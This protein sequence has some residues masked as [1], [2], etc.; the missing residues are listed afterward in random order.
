M[1]AARLT[2]QERAVLC[3]FLGE[4]LPLRRWFRSKARQIAGLRIERD[5]P[6]E[7][8]PGLVAHLLL[9]GVSFTSG[10]AER[11]FMARRAG[12]ATELLEHP[13]LHRIFLQLIASGQRLGHTDS[14]LVGLPGARASAIPADV[15]SR[16]LALE[17][18]NSAIAFGDSHFLKLFRVPDA[19]ES[20]DIEL[21]RYLTE[22][23][24][25]PN[26]APFVGTLEWHFAGEAP[27]ILGV[28][29]EMVPNRGD[30]WPE[31]IRL[32]N[33]FISTRADE[34]LRA[35]LALAELLG[36]RTAGMHTAFASPAAP[37]AIAPE[38]MVPADLHALARRRADLAGRVETLLATRVAPSQETEAVRAF[39]HAL[40]VR[41]TAAHPIPTQLGLKTRIHGDYHLGQVLLRHDGDVAI[42]DFEGEPARSLEE[43]RRKQTPLVD[44]AGMTRSFDYAAATALRVGGRPD[45]A[46]EWVEAMTTR[47]IGAYL[48]EA[49]SPRYLPP[50]LADFRALLTSLTIEKAIYE[51]AYELNNRPEWVP[52]PL[53]ALQRLA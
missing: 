10:S 51:L 6:L 30:A 44:V 21:T 45:R 23:A 26:I 18:S 3:E 50:E 4:E 37:R 11:Y 52:I 41:T 12:S 8:E 16:A 27:R 1:A 33:E 20:P 46:R 14:L 48:K 43:R 28:L 36:R 19:G 13:A 25:F 15:P 53:G 7:I 17:Q 29:Q 38:A 32:A 49:Q 35:S 34:H 40:A 24:G 2:E 47:F 39:L 9:V 31:A 5:L 22:Q 42:I